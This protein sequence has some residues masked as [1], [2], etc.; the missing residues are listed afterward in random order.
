MYSTTVEIIPCHGPSPQ[1]AQLGK[2]PPVAYQTVCAPGSASIT[3]PFARGDNS[4]ST[5]TKKHLKLHKPMQTVLKN[6]TQRSQ[7]AL[8]ITVHVGHAP[9]LVCSQ[10]IPYNNLTLASAQPWSGWGLYLNK[11]Q[12][13]LK[14]NPN[15]HPNITT[16][17]TSSQTIQT[18]VNSTINLACKG[19]ITVR[20]GH[21]PSLVCSQCISYNNVIVA[22]AQPWLGWGLYLNKS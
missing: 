13:T 1:L 7:I 14:T 10:C 18:N 3:I 11:S 8:K 9:S 5:Y 16:Y 19:Q 4:A 17:I 22:S 2:A 12:L 21:A 15:S 6:L 20:V